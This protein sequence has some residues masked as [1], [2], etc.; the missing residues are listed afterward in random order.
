[1]ARDA[2]VERED[3]RSA[4]IS[5]LYHVSRASEDYLQS[6]DLSIHANMKNEADEII[7]KNLANR[8]F[9]LDKLDCQDQLRTEA[10]ASSMHSST[11]NKKTLR[12]TQLW[13]EECMSTHD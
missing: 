9:Q 4:I 12:V 10:F 7:E 2:L 3:A 1:M 8:I 5:F 11:G 13:L 6:Y